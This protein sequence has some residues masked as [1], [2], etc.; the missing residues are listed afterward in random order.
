MT[1]IKN[2]LYFAGNAIAQ[3]I[4]GNASALRRRSASP[5]CRRESTPCTV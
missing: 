3:P 2:T 4:T 5:P 1:L